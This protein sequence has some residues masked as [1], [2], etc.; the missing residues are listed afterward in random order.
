MQGFPWRVLIASGLG[1]M[2]HAASVALA[3]DVYL[4]SGEWVRVSSLSYDGKVLVAESPWGQL[5]IPKERLHAVTWDESE[6]VD[7]ESV[8]YLVFR[9]GT[10]VR[11]TAQRV[12][13]DGLVAR[14]PWGWI[15]VTDV[16]R[17]VRSVGFGEVGELEEN[18]QSLWEF[19]LQD[20]S[21]VRGRVAGSNASGMAVETAYGVVSL[22]MEIVSP[23]SPARRSEER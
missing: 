4:T 19:L 9:D 7:P 10:R 17:L 2:A 8:R 15:V 23:G 5:S 6:R 1:L 13:P 3:A 12:G 11:A 18:P 21:L 14:A 20:G 16:E 22:P